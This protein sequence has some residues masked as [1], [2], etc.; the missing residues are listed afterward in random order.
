MGVRKLEDFKMNPALAAA[1]KSISKGEGLSREDALQLTEI[2]EREDL[3]RLVE[4]AGEVRKDRM[5][6]TVDLCAIMNAKSGNCPE[7]CAFCAQS[8][9]HHTEI[10]KYQMK[11]AGEILYQAVNAVNAGAHHFCIVTSGKSLSESD[12]ETVIRALKLIREKT[13]LFRCASLGLISPERA[14]KLKE[15]G[16]C[17]FNHNIE[18]AGSFFHKICTTHSQKERIQTVKNLRH[19]GI[20]VCCGGILNMGETPEQRIEFAFQLKELK[21]ES[22]PINFLNPRPGTALESRSLMDP[23][24]AIKYLAIFR[25][26]LP[27]SIIRLAGGRREALKDKE[28]LAFKAGVNGLLIGNYLTT[29]GPQTERDKELLRSLEFKF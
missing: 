1:E 7:D 18:T 23:F 5:G 29:E 4:L 21:P 11:S 25:L 3:F 27:E 2:K 17:R 19:A 24:E 10:D 12:F 9:C 13:F 26:I 14:R 20:E 15:A 28:E 22:V 16:L 8:A 6:N